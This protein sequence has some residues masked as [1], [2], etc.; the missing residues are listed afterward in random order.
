M[1]GQS[2]CFPFRGNPPQIPPALWGTQH[3]TKAKTTPRINKVGVAL[4][5]GRS[6]CVVYVQEMADDEDKG[7]VEVPRIKELE[8]QIAAL[9][10]QNSKLKN[11]LKFTT[12]TER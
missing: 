1:Q 7:V 10:K 9:T 11:E 2:T 5:R 3:Y 4:E 12:D 8:E 6:C